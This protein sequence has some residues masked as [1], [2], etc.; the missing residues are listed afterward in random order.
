MANN[1][2]TENQ[3][4]DLHNINYRVV[5]NSAASYSKGSTV[6]SGQVLVKETYGLSDVARRM[7][8]EGCA[9]KE[10]TIRLVLSEFAGMVAELVAEGRAVNIS[11]L[12]RF[13]PAV[14]GT[15]ADAAAP[16]DP[17]QHRLVV[18]ATVG[19][20]LR[21]AASASAVR[22]LDELALPK[23]T[24][25]YDVAT[26]QRDVLSS[27]GNFLVLGE[28]LTW[29]PEREDEGFFIS[30]LGAESRCTAVSDGTTPNRAIL[31][32]TQ[33]FDSSGLEVELFFRTR[34]GGETLRVVKYPNPLT[35]L[36]EGSE[37]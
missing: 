36:A 16:W 20:R 17:A 33:P 3:E 31:H 7:V 24:E 29:D 21:E 11:G 22:R 18:N 19:S 5:E 10:S 1:M 8:A 9:V 32:C 13:A 4:G 35:T 2:L 34:M 37:P 28:R 15:F 12:V 27:E 30:L 23:L 6:Y 14:R 25:L 26:L